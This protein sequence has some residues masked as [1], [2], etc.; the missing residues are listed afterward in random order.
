MESHTIYNASFWT[1]PVIEVNEEDVT[2]ESCR[3][4]ESKSLSK[5]SVRRRKTIAEIK[6]EL[7]NNIIA[8]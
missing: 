5:E 2:S 4:T 3:G 6:E 8:E 1:E 7:K